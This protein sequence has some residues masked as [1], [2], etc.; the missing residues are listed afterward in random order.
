MTQYRVYRVDVVYE[1][2]LEDSH[3]FEDSGRAVQF[4]EDEIQELANA[5][6]GA[7]WSVDLYDESTYPP[8]VLRDH[9][10]EAETLYNVTF[11]VQV[12]ADDPGHA[13]YRAK[14]EIREHIP[15]GE[16]EISWM[17]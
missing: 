6:P 14:G 13:E 3:Y 15:D 10:H 1:G 11:T 8:Q 2:A 12:Y 9:Y 7:D 17:Q 16:V 4:Y 5:A